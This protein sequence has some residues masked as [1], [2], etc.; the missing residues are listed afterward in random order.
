M[1]S[2]DC[3]HESWGCTTGWH[4]CSDCG[5]NLGSRKHPLLDHAHWACD[6]CIPMIVCAHDAAVYCDAC[7]PSKGWLDQI[8][9]GF[10]TKDSGKREE[11]D[12]GM[13]RDTNE[14][15]SRHD[16]LYPIGVPYKDQFLTRVADLLARGSV[17]YSAR[18]WEKASGQDELDRF[19]ES[20]LR[21]MIQWVAGETDEDHAAAVVFGLLGYE[22]TKWKLE[23]GT[24]D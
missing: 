19:K 24:D 21:H 9:E 10:I 16:L 2:E 1:V 11:Y 20:A 14:G 7:K 5:A 23:N 8:N 15:K 6:M 17:K 18:N 3:V 12:S 4:E 22:T 13:V